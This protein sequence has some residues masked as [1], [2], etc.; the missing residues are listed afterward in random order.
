MKKILIGFTLVL[1]IVLDLSANKVN[2]NANKMAEEFVN[3]LQ[4]LM[5]QNGGRAKISSGM[6]LIMALRYDSMVIT[7]VDIDSEEVIID[8]L[9][10]DKSVERKELKDYIYSKEYS[11]YMDKTQKESTLSSYC[12]PNTPLRKMINKGMS[13]SLTMTLD[14]TKQLISDF[15]V[16]KDKC[17]RVTK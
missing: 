2:N 3:S 6:Y 11:E 16:D 13:I 15:I 9:K 1:L 10:M 12:Q 14:G 7:R 4:K 17:L 5:K 8:T